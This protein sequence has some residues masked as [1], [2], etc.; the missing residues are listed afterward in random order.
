VVYEKDE[1]L[2]PKELQEIEEKANAL[3]A[4]DIP[5]V[6]TKMA[7][8]DAEIKYSTSIYDAIKPPESITE[9]NICEIAG[10]N[11]N[12]VKGNYSQKSVGSLLMS[13]MVNF[14]NLQES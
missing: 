9:L 14:L 2:S 12:A 13:K 10:W 8:K 7:K 3:I 1:K 11:V 4:E 5:I 6:V